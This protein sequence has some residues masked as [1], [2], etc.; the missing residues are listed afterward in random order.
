MK[1]KAWEP[2]RSMICARLL[3]W[4]RSGRKNGDGETLTAFAHTIAA[5]VHNSGAGL[6]FLD[7]N[8]RKQR[9]Y[10][11]TGFITWLQELADQTRRAYGP[12]Q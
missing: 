4:E 12:F 5:D 3:A 11:K 6:V 9:C 8:Q 7:F 10:L 1:V 2:H